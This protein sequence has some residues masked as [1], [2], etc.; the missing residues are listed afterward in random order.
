MVKQALAWRGRRA[1]EQIELPEYQQ[2]R[3]KV[4]SEFVRTFYDWTEQFADELKGFTL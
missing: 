1:A 3:E 2:R 4:R